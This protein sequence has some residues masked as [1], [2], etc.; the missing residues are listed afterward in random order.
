MGTKQRYFIHLA[1]QGSAY[2][3]WQRQPKALTIQQ[4]LEEIFSLFFR[5][6]IYIT[7]CGRTDTGVHA[8]SYF[9]HFD[10]EGPV[11]EQ[12]LIRLNAMLP[13]DI[14]VY[15]LYA[16]HEKA[17][18]RFDATHRA[19][20]YKISKRKN[21]F[22][23]GQYYFYKQFEKTDFSKVQDAASLILEY[24]TF[25]PFCKTDHDANSYNVDLRKSEW[26][27]TDLESWEYHIAADRFL[28]G[29]V[30]L[31]VGMCLRVG[32]GRLSLTAVREALDTQSLLPMSWSAPA[33]GLYLSEVLYPG[34]LLPPDMKI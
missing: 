9:A 26:I 18:T 5:Q 32:Q 29:M 30:R 23:Y 13:K 33:D 16:V 7:G 1:Y 14:A 24:N 25:F 19:Y 12:A 17:H 20:V 10:M 8:Y 28:R 6:P 2:H 15:Q 3:G 4:I 34:E 22:G 27:Q 31:I 21:P 11:P